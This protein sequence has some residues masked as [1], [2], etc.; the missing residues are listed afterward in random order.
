VNISHDTLTLCTSYTEIDDNDTMHDPTT[1]PYRI[2]FNTPGV[3]EITVRN[4]WATGLSASAT[5]VSVGLPFNLSVHIA[6]TTT[7]TPTGSVTLLDGGTALMSLSLSS[8]GNAT[9]TTSTLT[10]GSHTL[11]VVYA[12]DTNF[13]GSTVATQTVVIT[14][15]DFTLATTGP[16]SQTIPAGNTASFTF[17]VQLQGATLDSPITLASS[18]LPTGTTATFSPTYL[19]PGGAITAFTLTIQTIKPATK[20]AGM[21]GQLAALAILLLPLLPLAQRSR[22]GF[23]GALCL[24]LVIFTAGCGDRIYTTSQPGAVL[25]SYPILVSGTATSPTGHSGVFMQ[26][27]F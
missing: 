17:A 6:S 27:L 20:I 23:M 16:T 5:S 14:P 1:N 10:T 15:G 8:T 7:G 11:T 25:T 19:P 4:V 2:T 3:Y 24:V 18:G 26:M 12:G 21:R 9:F 22:R 13:T